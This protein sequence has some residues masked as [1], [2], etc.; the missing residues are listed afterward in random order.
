MV[1]CLFSCLILHAL[2]ELSFSML[3]YYG[4]MNHVNLLSLDTDDIKPSKCQGSFSWLIFALKYLWFM[5][6][7]TARGKGKKNQMWDRTVITTGMVEKL[8]IAFWLLDFHCYI[9]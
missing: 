7:K 8:W 5:M 6:I 2:L 3:K 1:I 4:T 9:L